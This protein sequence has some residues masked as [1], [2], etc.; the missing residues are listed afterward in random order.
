MAAFAKTLPLPAAKPA[1]Y[2]QRAAFDTYVADDSRLS[3]ND[4]VTLIV[5]HDVHKLAHRVAYLGFDTARYVPGQMIGELRLRLHADM[6]NGQG[7]VDVYKVNDHAFWG[8]SFTY[9]SRPVESARVASFSINDQAVD[10]WLTLTITDEELIRQ[11]LA[12]GKLSLML[13]GKENGVFHAISS[14][15]SGQFSPLLEVTVASDE[16]ASSDDVRYVCFVGVKEEN[17]ASVFQVSEFDVIDTQGR[18][19]EKS[20]WHVIGATSSENWQHLF[21][22]DRRTVW[23][24][25]Q[26]TPVHFI[27]DLNKPCDMA[28]VVFAPQAAGYTGRPAD[29]LIYGKSTEAEPWRLMGSRTIR[30]GDGN[31]PHIVF[32]GALAQTKQ[33]EKTYSLPLKT[34]PRTEKARLRTSMARSPLNVTGLYFKQPGIVCIWIEAAEPKASDFLGAREGHWAGSVSHSLHYGLNSFHFSS[35]EQPLYL[36]LS[37]ADVDDNDR[38]ALVRIMASNVDYYPVFTSGVTSQ[39]DWLNMV[40]AYDNTRFLEVNAKRLILTLHREHA[41]KFLSDINMQALADTYD[42][43]LMPVET[44]AGIT[45]GALRW[46]H[47]H[48]VNPYHFVPA[49]D[50]YMSATENRMK[51]QFGLTRRMLTEAHTFWGIWHEVGHTLQTTG[52]RWAGQGEVSVN[53]YAFGQRAWTRTA[54]EL[55][56][57]YDGPFTTAFNDLARVD[58]Y[59]QLQQSNREILFHHLFFVLGE[60]HMFDLHQRYRANMAGEIAD[61]EFLLG[62]TAEEQMNVMAM[63]SSKVSGRDLS[64]F[65]QFW[66]FPLTEQT[67]AIIS[68]YAFPAV[69]KFDQLPSALIVGR[70]PEDFN[71]VFNQAHAA[72]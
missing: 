10:G 18:I 57:A 36:Q 54:T 5:K 23:T 19:L 31:A 55:A 69:E 42:T 59:S 13:K 64:G 47:S 25:R 53:I 1:R 9:A 70:P 11:M 38:C 37:T 52:L 44:S 16:I 35:E 58:S 24:V 41:V 3:R 48:D 65:F 34:A 63:M 71:M 72:S 29:V 27:V 32:T 45:Q 60:R 8:T 33:A 62:T 28:A 61:P 22:G 12:D 56:Q 4:D 50:G 40:A 6:L 2:L 26:P 7:A 15:R 51:Y 39:A 68:G 20:D 43:N 66:K 49:A 67:L 21:D 46:L 14:S 30:H 17:G